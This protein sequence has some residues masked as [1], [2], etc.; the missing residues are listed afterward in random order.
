MTVTRRFRSRASFR[1]RPGQKP[2][3]TV[4][5]IVCEGKTERLYFDA[6]RIR[7]RLAAA[8][9]AIPDST[10]SAP[11]SVVNY[12]IDKSKTREGYDF[13]F[14]VIDRDPKAESFERALDKLH[15]NSKRQPL[16]AI[17]SVPCFE[18]WRLLHFEATDRPFHDCKEVIDQ[19][20][21]HVPRY[22]KTDLKQIEETLNRIEQ[23][24]AHAVRLFPSP[25]PQFNNP[26]TSVHRLVQHLQGI[27][28]QDPRA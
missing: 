26:H 13:I 14:C 17:V 16:T 9:V 25:D 8:E 28:A 24:L 11:I 10:G 21:R 4:T 18:Y 7:L 5:L 6:L 15:A 3:R 23:A 20:S 19:I 2:P 1:R 27:A 22:E 12:A